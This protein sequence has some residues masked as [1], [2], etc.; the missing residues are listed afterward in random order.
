VGQPCLLR[1]EASAERTPTLVAVF[2]RATLG[3]ANL[4]Q[5]FVH[6]LE[7]GSRELRHRGG[8]RSR[9]CQSRPRTR[10]TLAG[11]GWRGRW[12]AVVNHRRVDSRSRRIDADS[13]GLSGFR[14]SAHKPP[15][16]WSRPSLQFPTPLIAAATA[17]VTRPDSPHP[18]GFVRPQTRVSGDTLQRARAAATASNHHLLLT[19][20]KPVLQPKPPARPTPRRAEVAKPS[21]RQYQAPPRTTRKLPSSRHSGFSVAGRVTEESCRL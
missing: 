20:R 18:R 15:S 9:R 12:S 11:I 10:D 5:S 17:G 4:V 13:Q 3:H 14:F 21:G 8:K 7:A 19:T 2:A 6:D 1:D 16:L